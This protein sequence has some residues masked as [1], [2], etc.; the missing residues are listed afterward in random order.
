M[1]AGAK[2]DCPFTLKDGSSVARCPAPRSEPEVRENPIRR[3]RMGLPDD[4]GIGHIPARAANAAP[5]W[6]RPWCDHVTITTA[7]V[8]GTTP[9]DPS[10]SPHTV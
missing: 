10:L 2:T 6:I 5:E 3:W 9:S 4:A 1:Q 7:A 8:T